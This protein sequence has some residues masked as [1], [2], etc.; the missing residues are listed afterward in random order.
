MA[1]HPESAIVIQQMVEAVSKLD[2]YIV[3]QQAKGHDC[4]QTIASYVR[5][6]TVQLQSIDA[7]HVDTDAAGELQNHFRALG[8]LSED[9][10]QHL[11]NVV[12]T[13]HSAH[14][15]SFRA[16]KYRDQQNADDFEHMMLAS[17]WSIIEAH[18]QS[19]AINAICSRANAWGIVTASEK[20][21]GRMATI[22]ALWNLR[23]PNPA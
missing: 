23:D 20:L 6:F 19:D 14:A 4:H 7:V 17:D 18:G 13:K 2:K 11:Q 10:H 12:E 16:S 22:I 9:Q 5:K 3:D 21:K 15:E 8:W 1:S